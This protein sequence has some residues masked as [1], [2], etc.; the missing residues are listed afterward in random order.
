MLVLKKNQHTIKLP[1]M[2][3]CMGTPP[4]CDLNTQVY[5]QGIDEQK[6]LI[7]KVR[8]IISIQN[9][10]VISIQSVADRVFHY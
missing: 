2:Q 6:I 3:S 7:S 9:V 1:S 4:V 8:N 5:Q 10:S